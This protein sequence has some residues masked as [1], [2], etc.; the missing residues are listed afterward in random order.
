MSCVHFYDA[1]VFL[2][3]EAPETALMRAHAISIHVSLIFYMVYPIRTDSYIGIRPLDPTFM[4]TLCLTAQQPCPGRGVLASRDRRGPQHTM[5]FSTT[6]KGRP[7]PSSVLLISHRAA[8][9]GTGCCPENL[10]SLGAVLSSLPPASPPKGIPV[11]LP[12]RLLVSG[13][14]RQARKGIH[15]GLGQRPRVVPSGTFQLGLS[16]LREIAR[17]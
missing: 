17:L 14:M 4:C 11:P 7:Y 15:E 3:E 6:S 2:L 5:L 9:T 1:R 13:P 12:E 16:V 10:R 8:L